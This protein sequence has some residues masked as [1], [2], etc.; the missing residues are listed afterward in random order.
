MRGVAA[1]AVAVH[2]SVSHW[3]QFA[4]VNKFGYDGYL[5]VPFFFV[6]S[7]FVMMWTWQHGGKRGFLRRRVAR[8]YPVVLFGLSI[9]LLAYAV[10]GNPGAG[11]AG[12]RLSVVYSVLLVQAWFT[13]HPNVFQSWD[14]VAWTLSC[15][16]FFY[17]LSPVLLRWLSRPKERSCLFLVV[18]LLGGSF[19][20]QAILLPRTGPSVESF[21]LYS[22]IANLPFYVSGALVC[23]LILSGRLFQRS[24]SVLLASVGV[25]GAY[26]FYRGVFPLVQRFGSLAEVWMAPSFLFLIVCGASRDLKK[27]GSRPFMRSRPMVWLGEVSYSFYMTHALV[28]GALVYFVQKKGLLPG[29]PTEG[30]LFLIGFIFLATVVAGATH[31]LIELPGQRLVLRALSN[32]GVGLRRF[33][34]SSGPSSESS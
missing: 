26:A 13:N 33:V 23:R 32:C 5:G 15:E 11:H 17:V 9:S 10:F 30:E 31:R 21:F 8:I 18:G 4:V 28:L 14:G 2:H 27:P 19:L 3:K 22:P 7:G 6:L 29:N 12:N 24:H 20:I 34:A 25:V 16:A 1:V